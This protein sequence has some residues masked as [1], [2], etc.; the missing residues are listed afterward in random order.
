MFDENRLKDPDYFRE[1]RLESHSDHKYQPLY[2]L[3]LNG[4]WKFFHAKNP[5]QVIP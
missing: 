1:N 4:L 3:S 5:A 2:R